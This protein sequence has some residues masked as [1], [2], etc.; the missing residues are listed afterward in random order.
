GAL[1]YMNTFIENHDTD[2]A[3]TTMGGLVTVGYAVIFTLPGVP[4]VY[5]GGECGVGGRASDHTNRAPYKPCPGSP[6]ADTL[7]ALYSARREFGLWRG[8]AWAEQKRGRIIINRPGTRAEIDLNKIAI[9]GAGRQ[10][11]IPL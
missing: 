9:L 1:P 2:R 8:P 10:Q 11:E 5:A 3:V 6:I 7:R 4:S